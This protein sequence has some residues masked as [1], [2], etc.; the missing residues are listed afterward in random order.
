MAEVTTGLPAQT[1]TEKRA[2]IR[3][4]LG[5]VLEEW[6][7][8]FP[9]NLPRDMTFVQGAAKLL[10]DLSAD[11]SSL[12]EPETGNPEYGVPHTVEFLSTGT[13]LTLQLTPGIKTPVV[14]AVHLRRNEAGDLTHFGFDVLR[15]GQ[16]ETVFVEIGD[17]HPMQL[18]GVTDLLVPLVQT[19]HASL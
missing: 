12:T 1:E 15:Q 9:P 7:T 18:R 6:S 5:E 13:N 8:G 19:V 16:Y 11:V 2:T 4:A 3:H 14:D 10:W 17:Y